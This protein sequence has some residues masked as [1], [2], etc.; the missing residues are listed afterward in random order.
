MH[1]PY[2]HGRRDVHRDPHGFLTDRDVRNPFEAFDALRAHFDERTGVRAGRGD[3]RTAVLL[4]LEEEPR[5]GYQIIRE[6]EERSEG[7]WKPSPGSVYPTLQ[8]LADEGLVSVEESGGRKTYSLTEDGTG[9][10]AKLKDTPAPWDHDQEPRKGPSAELTK[11]GARLGQAVAQI[12]TSGSREQTQQAVE[13][14]DEA[15]RK[16][17]TILAQE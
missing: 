15:R 17:Y 13:V 12:A 4:L 16:I 10:A 6:I 7:A 9:Q 14:V 1:T 5:H 3:V 2:A 8:M 11:A